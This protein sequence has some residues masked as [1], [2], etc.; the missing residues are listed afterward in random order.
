MRWSHPADAAALCR[1]AR[2]VFLQAT[3]DQSFRVSRVVLALQY[4]D[5]APAAAGKRKRAETAG[6]DGG[7]LQQSILRFVGTE[8]PQMSC[9]QAAASPAAATAASATVSVIHAGSAQGARRGTL[10]DFFGPTSAAPAAADTLNKLD[11][12]LRDRRVGGDL[13]DAAFG[14]GGSCDVDGKGGGAGVR[15]IRKRTE[16]KRQKP[17]SKPTDVVI[18]D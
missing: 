11:K 2:D 13:S 9:M 10:R 14:D 7:A 5:G 1:L 17:E 12:G 3:K 18:I 16:E 4:P 6:R 15:D 8:S